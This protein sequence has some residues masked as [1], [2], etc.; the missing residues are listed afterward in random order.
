[1][2]GRT[3]GDNFPIVNA[4]QPIFGGGVYD[5]FVSKLNASGSALLFSTY[6]GGSG[7]ESGASPVSSIALDP[8]GN[9]YTTGY[10]DSGDFP[11]TPG[12]YQVD[13][14]PGPAGRAY[15]VKYTP[16]G[17]LTYA[18]FL[19]G[20]GGSVG[21]SVA[22]DALGRAY[23]AGGTGST[24]FPTTPDAT[25]P[26]LAGGAGGN[27]AYIT[28]LDATG[29]TALFSTYLGGP[30]GYDFATGIGLGPNGS[31]LVA[32]QTE[33]FG[34]FPTTA[35]A[36]QPAYGGG[37]DAFVARIDIGPPPDTTPPVITSATPSA[38]S[39]WPPNHKMTPITIA[40][41]ATDAGNSAPVCSIASVSSN[42]P[43]NGLGDG[44]IAPDWNVTGPLRV[45]L[46]AERSGTGTGRLYTIAVTC[47]DQAGNISAPAT[48][49]V[50]VPR[51]R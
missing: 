45:E 38:A 17:Q 48:V 5:V 32:G 16:D 4:A 3:W 37:M 7:S 39:L 44:D 34:S 8:A 24:N 40:V 49:T 43:E 51:N 35:G 22:A 33:G 15:A 19:A 11:R 12:A 41:Q 28:V 10:T 18:T 31:I 13:P 20:N 47:T 26:S 50:T 21:T 2:T 25:Q 30:M 14:G 6:L 46:R 23:L 42:E 36:V 1:V 29:S 9:A 27:D